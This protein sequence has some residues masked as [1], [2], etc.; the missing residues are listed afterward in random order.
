MIN[1]DL[2]IK[3]QS[4]QELLTKAGSENYE[5]SEIEKALQ[6]VSIFL[7]YLHYILCLQLKYI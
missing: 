2:T 7:A 3:F 1:I 6:S 4:L 5:I